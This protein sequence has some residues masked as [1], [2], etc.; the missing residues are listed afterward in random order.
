[1]TL[2]TDIES[3]MNQRPLT[4]L[5]SDPKNPCPITPAHLALG[6]ALE[7]V[8]VIGNQIGVTTTKRYRHLQV[9]LGHFWRRWAREYVPTLIPRKKW[10]TEMKVP[11]VGD[12][13]LITEEATSRPKWKLGRVTRTF[14][15]KDGLIRTFQ[16]KTLNG[17]INRPIQRLHLLEPDVTDKDRALND[18]PGHGVKLHPRGPSSG[19]P[20]DAEDEK[21]E[22]SQARPGELQPD[23]ELVAR[24]SDQG[25]EDVLASK[26]REPSTITRSGRSSFKPIRY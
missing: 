19:T 13:C 4:Y 3:T 15:G 16:L 17:L 7:H 20:D 10:H 25:R 12:V 6:R 26:N 2:L 9:L 22:E 23:S 21:D 14:Q 5:G 8:P 1:M 11:K 18:R 24:W